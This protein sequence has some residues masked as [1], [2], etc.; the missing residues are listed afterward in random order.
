[1]ELPLFEQRVALTCNITS[2]P[3]TGPST[4]S[5]VATSSAPAALGPYQN[6]TL[7]QMAGAF[8]SFQSGLSGAGN[9]Q[10]ASQGNGFSGHCILKRIQFHLND[11]ILSIVHI[12]SAFFFR[13]NANVN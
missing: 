13:K 1:M 9:L 12:L 10:N 11:G 5:A 2:P 6:S 3:A 4:S 7:V 8:H